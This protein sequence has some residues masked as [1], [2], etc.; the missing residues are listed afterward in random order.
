MSRANVGLRLALAIGLVA[1]SVLRLAAQEPLVQ[2]DTIRVDVASRASAGFP[3]RSRAVEVLTAS[4]LRTLPVRTVMEAL[5]WVVAADVQPRSA[6]QADLSL[7][8]STFEQVLVLVDGVRMSDPQTG[9]FDLDLTVPLDRVERIEVLKG[10]ASA[11]YGPDAFGGVVNVVTRE[12][13]EGMAAMVEGGS[14]GTWRAGVSA[15]AGTGGVRFSGSGEWERSDGHRDSTDHKILQVDSR[16]S[17]PVGGGRLVLQ[18]GHARRDFGA[19]YFYA[20]RNSYEETRTTTVSAGWSGEIGGGFTLHPRLSLRR[21]D[22]DFILIRTNPDVYQNVHMSR[23]RGGELLLRRRSPNGLGLAFALGGELYRDDL[24][25]DNVALQ[26][27]ALGARSEDRRAAFAEA[28]WGGSRA[29]VSAGL[30][31]DWQEGFG[32]AWSPSLSGSVDLASPL[33]LRAAWGRSYRTP[34]WTDRYYSDPFSLGDPDLEPE[35]SWSAEIGADLA[36]TGRGILRVTAFR[37]ASENLID[38]VKPVG[39]PADAPHEVRNVGSATFDGLEVALEG[40]SIGGFQLKAGGSLLSVEAKEA[41]GLISRYVHPITQRATAG[42]SRVFLGERLLLAGW[43]MH[44]R[45]LPASG[46][47]GEPYELVGLR[48]RL[49]LPY[50][51]VELSATNLTDQEYR[52]IRG[53]QAAGRALRVAYRLGGPGG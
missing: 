9:H 18:A 15:D 20:P 52:D 25:S 16:V 44:E 22:D 3:A 27:P 6:A 19:H 12:G 53:N 51:E 36:L 11:L 5:Q 40:V 33:R 45:R 37:R 29:S 7:R 41:A 23:Q 2:L 46:E 26:Q 47:R 8:G 14:F 35:R 1:C 10:P 34:T 28:G 42:V 49:R 13:E 32:S 38:W 39:S 4:E 21:H 17:V 43:I 24:K 48:A 31:A 50:G 30:R